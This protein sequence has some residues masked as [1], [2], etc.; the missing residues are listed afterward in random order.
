MGFYSSQLGV[1]FLGGGGGGGGRGGGQLGGGVDW[2]RFATW[3]SLPV[4]GARYCIDHSLSL[5]LFILGV[6]FK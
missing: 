3:R 4:A 1:F 2:E 5:K 6:Q